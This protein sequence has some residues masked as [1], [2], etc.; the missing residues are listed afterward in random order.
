MSAQHVLKALKEIEFESFIPELET[1]LEK[2]RKKKNDRKSMNDPA[3]EN[4]ENAEDE[5]VETIE[6]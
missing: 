5:D 1:Q 6:D 3:T 2:F 4:T